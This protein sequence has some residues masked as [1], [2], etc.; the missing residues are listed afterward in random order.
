MYSYSA[1]M[2]VNCNQDDAVFRYVSRNIRDLS[3]KLKVK[4][5]RYCKIVQNG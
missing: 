3:K 1:Q 5:R 4:V 2:F